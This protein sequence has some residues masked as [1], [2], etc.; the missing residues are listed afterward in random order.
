VHL[1]FEKLNQLDYKEGI[2][3][4]NSCISS[5]SNASD[6]NSKSSLVIVVNLFLSVPYLIIADIRFVCFPLWPDNK[7]SENKE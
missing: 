4:L 1:I 7:G 5:G 6:A 3:Y 2:S